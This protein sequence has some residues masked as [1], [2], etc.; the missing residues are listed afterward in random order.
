M[1][2]VTESHSKL[3]DIL[4]SSTSSRVSLLINEALLDSAKVI[5][6][7]LTS[8][9]PTC[10]QADRKYYVPAKDTEFLFYHPPP[11][12]IIVDAVNSKGRQ[13]QF[14]STPYDQD[15]NNLDLFG[16]KAYSSATLQFCI[17]NYQP[18]L[19][20][21]SYQNYAKLSS[22]I[23]QLP[24]SQKEEFKAIVNEG[25][26]VAKISLQSALDVADMVA[27]SMSTAIVM[28]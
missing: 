20:K 14:K 2:E 23:E 7:A 8:V 24:N 4:H 17:A 15:W 22:F 18:L 13:H 27:R 25:Q 10:R 6:Q 5:W 12:S 1:Q 3:V 26:L 16:R 9:P 19:A 21:Y 28:K 11:N